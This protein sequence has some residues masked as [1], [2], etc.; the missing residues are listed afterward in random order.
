MKKFYLFVWVLATIM[1][2]SAGCK[3]E[4]QVPAYTPPSELTPAN[5]FIITEAGT[6]SFAVKKG[7]SSELVEGVSTAEVLWESFGT[8]SAPQEK[9]I[10]ESVSY[11]DGVITF[12]T[13]SALKD[14]NAVI[15]AK[16]AND[17]ILW[18]WH[19]WVCEGYEAFDSAQKYLDGCF[20]MDR[21]LG[22][23]SATPG[24]IG[25]LG[26]L[27]Q[28]GRKDPFLGWDGQTASTQAKSTGS[29]PAA[30]QSDATN[31]NVE[32]ATKNPTTFIKCNTNNYDWY[33]SNTSSTDKTR[34]KSTKT[35]YDPC[36][37]GWRVC[38]MVWGSSTVSHKTEQKGW[39]LKFG[40]DVKA[41]YPQ[42][43]YLDKDGAGLVNSGLIAY[44]W[45]LSSDGVSV[46]G[47][48]VNNNSVQTQSTQNRAAGVSVRCQREF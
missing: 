6:F 29:W 8:S 2:L 33:Y 5:C 3:K 19:I 35:K 37:D 18:S 11:Q 4:N 42:A 32:F 45:S 16:D 14:G 27:Y 39:E 15:A 30:V 36:P 17:N 1:I 20:I 13:P 24:E 10:I 40:D 7:N 28:W 44:W 9:D 12:S 25:S 48:E 43:G 21:N 47:L 41:W 46:R 23:T 38:A 34:W 22:A 26:L 31:G